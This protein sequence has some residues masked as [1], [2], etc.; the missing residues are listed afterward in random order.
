MAHVN[1]NHI[2][3]ADESLVGFTHLRDKISVLGCDRHAGG[4]G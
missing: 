4:E 3:L 2:L 1:M